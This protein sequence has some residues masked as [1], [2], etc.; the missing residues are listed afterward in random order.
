AQQGLLYVLRRIS[1]LFLSHIPPAPAVPP[2]SPGYRSC[3]DAPHIRTP[4]FYSF[5]EEPQS[6]SPP[7]LP[8][9]TDVPPDTLSASSGAF[10]LPKPHPGHARYTPCRSP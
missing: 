2:V 4:V 3:R 5:A 9:G 7:A 10:L 8:F 1:R 6:G